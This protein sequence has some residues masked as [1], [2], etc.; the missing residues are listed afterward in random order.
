MVADAGAEVRLVNKDVNIQE[1]DM[2]RGDDPGKSDK[3][4][5]NE[6]LKEEEKRIMTM[7]DTRKL[8]AGQEV[9]ERLDRN[10]LRAERP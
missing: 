6:A 8:E 7:S 2:G 5:T 9:K 4:A 10:F 1:D 3:V